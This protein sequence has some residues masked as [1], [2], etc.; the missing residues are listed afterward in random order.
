[1]AERCRTA[2][3]RF[4]FVSVTFSRGVDRREVE[5]LDYFVSTAHETVDAMLDEF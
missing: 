4:A 1:M 5:R 3:Y 2:L